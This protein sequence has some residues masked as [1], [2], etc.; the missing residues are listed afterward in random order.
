MTILG[1]C[2]DVFRAAC[3]VVNIDFQNLGLKSDRKEGEILGTKINNLNLY[4][5][6]T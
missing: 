5:F 6:T 1:F 2:E 4:I 3:T